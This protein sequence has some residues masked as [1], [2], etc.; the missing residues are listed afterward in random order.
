MPR[1]AQ[2]GSARRL[3]LHLRRISGWQFGGNGV[4]L[5][6]PLCPP[7]RAQNGFE[8]WSAT[9]LASAASQ[10]DQGSRF[11]ET[12]GATDWRRSLW[13]RLG[14]GILHRG[15][16]RGCISPPLSL[17]PYVPKTAGTLA[18]ELGGSDWPSRRL[19][20]RVSKGESARERLRPKGE[21]TRHCETHTHTHDTHVYTQTPRRA[22]RTERHAEARRCTQMQPFFSLSSLPQ[23]KMCGVS[24]SSTEQ[25]LPP[26]PV[27]DLNCGRWPEAVR[28]K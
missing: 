20:G 3:G 5:S 17:S 9:F 7:P 12:P 23:Q 16:H 8:L 2:G 15:T 27:N 19:L 24:R 22:R 28:Q 4:C 10:L 6:P 25:P 26:P 1:A 21:Q 11:A 13:E 14:P 18:W